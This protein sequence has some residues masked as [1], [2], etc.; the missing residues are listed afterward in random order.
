VEAILKAQGRWEQA[1]DR[2]LASL[3]E[4]DRARSVNE[5]E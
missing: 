4:R 1:V 3:V 2:Y 5:K